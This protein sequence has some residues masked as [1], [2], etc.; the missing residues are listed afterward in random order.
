MRS[1][2]FT[3]GKGGVG[4]S[5]LAVLF[6]MACG[7]AQRQVAVLDLDQQATANDWIERVQPENVSLYTNGAFPEILLIDTPAKSELAEHLRKLP[8]ADLFL[9]P[10]TTNVSDSSVAKRTALHL[11]Q[12]APQAKVRLVFNLVD[13]RRSASKQLEEFA[14][15]IEC[16]ALK[17]VLHLRACYAQAQTDGWRALH[18]EAR[19]ELSN[20]ALEAMTL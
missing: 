20:L 15:V 18:A 1:I 10:T 17:S 16:P 5:T 6:A 12:I 19:D 11:R 13:A 14:A 3:N 7:K 4:K 2:I 9:I 8:S